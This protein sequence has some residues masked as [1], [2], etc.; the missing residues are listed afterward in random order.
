MSQ[1]SAIQELL[2]QIEEMHVHPRNQS[3]LKKWVKQP[4]RALDNKWRHVAVP[5]A[6]SGGEIPIAVNMEPSLRSSL[7]E[8]SV[9]EYFQNPE[10]YLTNY[11]R[12]EIF[13]FTEIRDDVPLLLQIP[14]YHTAYLEGAL[15]GVD[16]VYLD[17][18]DAVLPEKPLLADLADVKKL[19]LPR[20]TQS[21]KAMSDALRLYEFVC[22]QVEGRE[23]AVTFV[24]WLRNPFGLATW[25]YGEERLVEAIPVDPEG[26]HRLL[27]YAV[28][29]RQSWIEERSKFLHQGTH[30]TPCLYSDS[31][32]SSALTPEEYLEFVQPYELK[33][34]E[35]HGGIY[36]WHCCGDS[37]RHL[38]HLANLPLELF[39]VGPWTSAR[40]AAEAF[41]SK[42]TALE[43]CL[44]KHGHYGPGNWSSEDDIFAASEA[45]MAARI[46]RAVSDAQEGGA[47]AFCIEAGPLHRTHNPARDLEAVQK[48][49]AAARK[50]L[51]DTGR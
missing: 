41:S 27:D 45:G 21:T 13:H 32:G 44:Q 25:L 42:G 40:A 19:P 11:L 20:V 28:H 3:N 37:T 10:N 22:E 46:S 50:V 17:D 15:C 24:D 48:W 23:F 5:L 7:F 16:I 35:E 12:H 30:S 34:A 39:H 49:V 26:V 2:D 51:V 6:E 4:A 31:V 38:K 43:I 1:S 8:Y 9:R 29:A 47:T 36:Y 33:V 14:I 18:H